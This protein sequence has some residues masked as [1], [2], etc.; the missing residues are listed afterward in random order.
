MRR[1]ARTSSRVV[2]SLPPRTS[3]S[4][5]V[6][7]AVG[8]ARATEQFGAGVDRGLEVEHHGV[9]IVPD[10]D[11]GSGDRPGIG[12][13]ALDAEPVQPVGEVPDGLLVGEVRLLDPAGGLLADDAEA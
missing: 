10:E 13:G 1:A 9:V 5:T 2:T 6:D 7:T 12:E 8:A 3:G 11:L 4:V